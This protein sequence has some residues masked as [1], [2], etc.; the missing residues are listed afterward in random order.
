LLLAA[1]GSA[2]RLALSAP[3]GDVRLMLRRFGTFVLLLACALAPVLPAVTTALAASAD[4]CGCEP[5]CGCNP[6]DC[7]MPAA[8]RVPAPPAV[9]IAVVA[10]AATPRP[11]TGSARTVFAFV[12]S[13]TAGRA[14]WALSAT[15]LT[16]A[17]SV[18]LFTEHCSFLL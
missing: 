18:P 2:I 4:C 1:S 7:P 5:H 11:A 3:G 10:R 13:A 14:A 9:S 15:A 12:S 16:P 6:T 17:A 8:A